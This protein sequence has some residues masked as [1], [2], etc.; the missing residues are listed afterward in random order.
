M[1]HVGISYNFNEHRDNGGVAQ[2]L[3]YLSKRPLP[4]KDRF[5]P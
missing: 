3:S 2:W 5:K 1:D 4:L